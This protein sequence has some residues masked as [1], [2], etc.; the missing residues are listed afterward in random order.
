VRLFL[1]AHRHGPTGGDV[2]EAGFLFDSPATGD[3]LGLAL[4]LVLERLLDMLEGVQV[5]DF[6]LGPEGRRAQ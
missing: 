6:G 2:P 4:D 5:L 3:D 1:T